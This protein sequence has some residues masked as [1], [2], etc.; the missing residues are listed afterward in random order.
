M[1]LTVLHPGQGGSQVSVLSQQPAVF[2]GS[3]VEGV[4]GPVRVPKGSVLACNWVWTKCEPHLAAAADVCGSASQGGLGGNVSALCPEP[5]VLAS[6]ELLS[7]R[8]H[9]TEL[10]TQVLLASEPGDR[11]GTRAAATEPGHQGHARAPRRCQPVRRGEA[12][13]GE[14][15]RPPELPRGFQ[16]L[17]DVCLIRSLCG[18]N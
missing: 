6:S 17:S 8:C 16:L 13:R 11:G 15:A 1:K 18:S 2:S 14:S 12:P 10:G 5:W 3:G 9:P 4:P 7:L